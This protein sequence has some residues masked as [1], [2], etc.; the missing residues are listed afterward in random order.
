MRALYRS[1]LNWA[2]IQGLPRAPSQT[3]SE[4]LGILCQKFPQ[5]GSGL[6]LITGAYL[7]ARY[8]RSPISDQEFEIAQRAWQQISAARA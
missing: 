3:P 6:K 8:S 5:E 1:L 7:D 4:Y 2:A